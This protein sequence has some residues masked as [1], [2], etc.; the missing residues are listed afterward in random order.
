MKYLFFCLSVLTFLQPV[1]GQISGRLVTAGGQPIPFA[2]VLLLQGKDST[3]IKGTLTDEKGVYQIA[4]NANGNY[5]LRVTSIGYRTWHS[6][7]FTSTRMNFGDQVLQV[8]AQQLGEVVVQAEKPL[9]QQRMDG[10]VVN[11]ESSVMSKGSSVLQVLERSPGVSLDYQNG[12]FSL[13]GKS[14][15]M[16]MLNGKLVRMPV[17]KVVNLLSS[18]SANDVE[19]IE[20]LNTPGAAYDAEGGGGVINIVMKK[21]KQLGT[22]GSFSLTGGYGKREK[23]NASLYLSRNGPRTNTYGS[24]TF[25]HDNTYSDMF[26]VSTQDMPVL[27]GRMAVSAWDTTR[28]VQNDHTVVLGLDSRLS[29]KITVGANVTFNSSHSKAL[30]HNFLHYLVLPD[31]LLLFDGYI[32]ARNRW[33]SVISSLYLE[34]MV[35]KEDKLSL[36]V[37]YLYFNNSTP[38]EVN[39]TFFD[40]NGHKAGTNNDTLFSPRQ[41]G[42]SNT[43]IH[44]GVAKMDFT[45]QWSSKLKMETGIKGTYTFASSGSGIQSLIDGKWIARDET[46]NQLEMRE[47]IGAAYASFNL[48][49]DSLTNL[50]AGARYE[51]SHTRMDSEIPVNRKLGTLFPGIFINRKLSEYA[52]LTLSYTKRIS[53]PSYNDLASYVTYSDPTAVYTGNPFLRP[54]ITHNIKLGYNYRNYAISL[55]WS[56]DKHP[57]ARYQL[58]QSAGAD[59]LYV[60]PQNL[61]YMRDITLQTN[62]PWKVGDWWDMSYSFTGTLRRYSIV[63]TL[64]PVVHNYFACS[65]NFNETF[66]LPQHYFI[67][68]SGWYNS[69]FYNGSIKITGL[70]A[71]NA[72]IKKDLNNNWGSLQLSVV[73]IFRTIHVNP[74]Y[75]TLTKEAFDI[76][77]HVAINVESAVIPIAKLTWSKSFG[78]GT[79]KNREQRSSARDEQERVRKD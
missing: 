65:V 41:K 39:N 60:S 2:N 55:L 21:H 34:K 56:R 3:L 59:L 52:G 10:L 49:L 71:I 53:R 66:K 5:V 4:Y 69:T 47:G 18:M 6:A 7:V 30:V 72:G 31:S 9:F 62:L 44:V 25:S 74:Y 40:E 38:S 36:D 54:A 61:A 45:K 76:Q 16:V 14:G 73:D 1:S 46:V 29:E 23:G 24:Y 35:R 67:E 75:G 17:E 33:N 63:H 70:G 50:I 27:G 79:F 77:N 11:V 78:T 57:I 20:I 22:N 28:R 19:K 12:G 58:T 51:Y 8:D 43:A 32:H 15:V 13:N 42:T 64:V 48:Q 37:D 68:V 26:I